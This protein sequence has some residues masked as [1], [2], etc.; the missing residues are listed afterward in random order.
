M[1]RSD[2]RQLCTD[3]TLLEEASARNQAVELHHIK[4]SQQILIAKSRILF[5]DDKYL[6]LDAPTSN[7]RP[8]NFGSGWII[9]AYTH[10]LRENITFKSE[11][12]DNNYSIQINRGKTIQGIQITR[13]SEIWFSQRRNDYRVSMASMKPV[14]AEVHEVTPDNP[15]TAPC[16]AMRAVG[17]LVNVSTGGC[18]VVLPNDRARDF[19]SGDLI[20]VGFV[21]PDNDSPLI[22]QAELCQIFPVLE[23]RATRLGIRFIEWPTPAQYGRMRR[24]L[25]KFVADVQRATA[26]RVRVKHR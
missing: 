8:I 18:A 2:K 15:E 13:P 7:G 24:P 17:R 12:L 3:P 26:Q 20:F 19:L 9:D 21:L 16:E 5:T 10:V 22:F 11:V 4:S 6:Y 1:S 25:E 14:E 23:G